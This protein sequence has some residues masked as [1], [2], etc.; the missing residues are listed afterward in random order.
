MIKENLIFLD[1]DYANS[2]EL[3]SNISDIL[4]SK[5]YVKESFKNA[6]LKREE[7]YPTAIQTE[8]FG[9][10]IPHTDTEHINTPGIAFV[11]LKKDC[12]FKEMCTNNNIKVNMAFILLVNEK[13][14]QVGLLTKLMELFSKN[15][16]LEQLYNENDVNKLVNIL[17]SQIK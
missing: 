8:K 10:A 7:I 4:I 11:K 17:T 1:C 16:I 6:I 13:E 12:T 3:L 9:L 14:N 15:E 5:G 2:K